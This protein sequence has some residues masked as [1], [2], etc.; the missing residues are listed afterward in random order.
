MVDPI[1]I[2]SPPVD[3]GADRA[4]R[5]FSAMTWSR[6]RRRPANLIGVGVISALAAVALGANLLASDKPIIVR[7]DGHLYL[8]PDLVEPVALRNDDVR[9]LTARLRPDQGDWLLPTPV[10]FGPYQTDLGIDLT[11]P[12]RTHW[13]GTDEIGR[14]VLARMIHGTRVSLLVGIVAVT[15]YVVIGAALG[16]LSGF[17]GG[18]VDAAVSRIIEAVLAFPTLLI[19]LAVLGMMQR[20]TL[21]MLMIV[22]GFTRW[23]DVAR[24]VRAEFLRLKTQEFVV[25]SRALG[26]GD[27]RLIARHI[28]P[29]AMGPVFVSATFGIAGAILLESTLSFLGFGV[30]PP[31]PSWGEILTQAER[32]V[33]YPGAWWLAVFPGLAIF[34]TVISYNVVGEGL[35]DAMDPRLSR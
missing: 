29:N 14:D 9:S 3:L 2:V 16:A 24:L 19:A 5:S 33:S 11:A 7:V 17:Y 35:R 21:T 20:P 6:F 30:Q 32:Y 8:F 13:L 25:A 10:R 18:W 27:L 4:A 28:V 22:I 12:N 1:D 15:I 34:L 23:P 26:G 31:T